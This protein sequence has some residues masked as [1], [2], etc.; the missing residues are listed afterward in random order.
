MFFLN[1]LLDSNE[2]YE[3]SGCPNYEQILRM[4]GVIVLKVGANQTSLPAY[5][6]Q[7]W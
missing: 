7:K 5:E 6:C 1:E 3:V 2:C 4:S